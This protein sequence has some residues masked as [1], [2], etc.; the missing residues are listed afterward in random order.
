MFRSAM[1]SDALWPGEMAGCVVGG[2]SVLLANV[3]GTIVAFR[4]RCA[5][6]GAPL[7]AGRFADGRIR[8]AAHHWEY[9]AR[10]GCGINPATA[11]L[12]QYP[13]TIREGLI[14][15]DVGS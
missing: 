7:S 1:A 10:T 12:H 13:V 15:V 5:H 6:L 11:A 3:D 8:C 14:L 2:E 4:D 9:D